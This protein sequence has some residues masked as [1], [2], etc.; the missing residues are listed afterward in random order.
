[1]Q[2]WTITKT[3]IA[4]FL[5]GLFISYGPAPVQIAQP[6][7]AAGVPSAVPDRASNEAKDAARYDWTAENQLS[8]KNFPTGMTEAHKKNLCA[9]FIE[10]Q[11]KIAGDVNHLG[12]PPSGC[13]EVHPSVPQGAVPDDMLRFFQA[14]YVIA[15][16]KAGNCDVYP[17]ECKND[18]DINLYMVKE[19]VCAGK[20][21]LPVHRRCP[22]S[23]S[24][25][26]CDCSTPQAEP[27][28]SFLSPEDLLKPRV[29]QTPVPQPMAPP[30][31]EPR[32]VPQGSG[33][34]PMPSIPKS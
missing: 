20:S 21:L 11:Y 34:H 18:P 22:C 23:C 7:C 27:K 12:N 17:D 28:K 29:E 25:G 9:A 13:E 3:A 32:A 16:D 19:Y 24:Y 33:F 5:A 30:Q 26:A 6:A 8:V 4:T 31:A 14:G 2:P 15:I 1:M 10:Q